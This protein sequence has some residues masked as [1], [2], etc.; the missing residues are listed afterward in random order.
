M[1]LLRET[2]MTA[3]SSADLIAVTIAEMIGGTPYCTREVNRDGSAYFAA[4]VVAPNGNT[5]VSPEPT[6]L[7]AM[8][9]L[10]AW[11]RR[12]FPHTIDVP[13]SKEGFDGLSFYSDYQDVKAN[14]AIA[15]IVRNREAFERQESPSIREG[16][17]RF[18]STLTA[19]ADA[20]RCEVSA[21]RHA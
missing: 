19:D 9:E 11:V 20:R 18:I 10:L 1:V 6:A 4:K 16:L 2:T 15:A 17:E 21:V 14:E 3:K 13:H 8:A 5:L 7:A 12:D